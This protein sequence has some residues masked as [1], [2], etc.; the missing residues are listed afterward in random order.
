[1]FA[2]VLIPWAVYMTIHPRFSKDGGLHLDFSPISGE[3]VSSAMHNI[4]DTFTHQLDSAR[5]S[6]DKHIL[7]SGFSLHEKVRMPVLGPVVKDGMKPLW[8]FQHQGGDA[9]FALAANYRVRF[10]QRFVTTLRNT[11][12]TGDIV[13][14]VN[15]VARMAPGVEKSVTPN[16]IHAQ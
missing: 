13:L 7:D 15:P 5:A 4:S 3:T 12:F 2:T 9:I 6:L 11:G 16:P 10:Y 1:M 14:A 8:G